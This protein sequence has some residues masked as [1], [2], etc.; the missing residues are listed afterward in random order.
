MRR[1]PTG[2]Q[3]ARRRTKADSL[4]GSRIAKGTARNASVMPKTMASTPRTY[5]GS[6]MGSPTVGQVPHDEEGDEQQEADEQHGVGRDEDG[7]GEGTGAQQQGG[8]VLAR[9][10]RIEGEG[11]EQGA[12]GELQPVDGPWHQRGDRDSGEAATHP[13]EL[14]AQLHREQTPRGPATGAKDRKSTRLNSSHVA[15][16]YAVFCLQKKN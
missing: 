11:D 10:C 16:S 3:T 15:S 1:M 9:A 14:E 4:S 8:Q 2:I 6:G 13:V 12:Q 7:D 5:Q